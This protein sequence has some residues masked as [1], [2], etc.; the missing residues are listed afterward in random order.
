[1]SLG[2]VL[3]SFRARP[4]YETYEMDRDEWRKAKGTFLLLTRDHIK[5]LDEKLATL[6]DGEEKTALQNARVEL[7]QAMFAVVLM[8]E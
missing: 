5:H 8:T 6:S 3:P 4:A 7:L 2:D 1:M